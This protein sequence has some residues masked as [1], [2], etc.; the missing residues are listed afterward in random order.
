MKTRAGDARAD[1]RAGENSR[2]RRHAGQ[3][4]AA[5]RPARGEGIRRGDRG[6]WRGG[7]REARRGEARSRAARRDDAGPVRLRR[8]PA[9]PR[10]PGDGAAAGR[11]RDVARSARRAAEGHRG[12]RRRFPVEADQPARAFRA[13]ALA[14]AREG[15]AG[16]GAAAGRRA[17]GMECEAGG[18]R[19]RAGRADA[20]PLAA[21][22]VLLAQ[23]SPRPS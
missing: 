23:E 16:R 4:Q 10:G 6:D 14:A 19:R 7:A 12:G 22:A 15:A 21:E 11:A 17:E 20:A 5:R 18:A 3:R 2:R 13:R 8:L 1:E 9:H